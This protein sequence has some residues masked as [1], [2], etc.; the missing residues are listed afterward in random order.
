MNAIIPPRA[1]WR[2]CLCC[3]NCCGIS[4]GRL[5]NTV[6][7]R[8]ERLK[9]QYQFAAQGVRA[10]V[11]I[12]KTRIPKRYWNKTLRELQSGT[13]TTQQQSSYNSHH[14]TYPAS[15]LLNFGSSFNNMPKFTIPHE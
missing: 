11:E 8:I 10:K 2:A 13:A 9:S 4:F 6:S 5:T 1:T 3:Q 12:R 15:S 14:Q 7:N